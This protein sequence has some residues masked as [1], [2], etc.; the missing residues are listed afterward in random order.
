M[1]EERATAT[2]DPGLPGLA[3]ALD[4]VAVAP[5]LGVLMEGL[6]GTQAVAVRSIQV[7]RHK[8]GRRALI[9]YGVEQ[10]ER[11]VPGSAAGGGAGP[12]RVLG[13]LRGKG[14]DRKTMAAMQALRVHGFGSRS[15]D[16]VSV[17]EVIGGW[18]E[19]Q[20]WFQRRVAGLSLEVCL[21][22]EAGPSSL[23]SSSSLSP[24]LASGSGSE[25]EAVRGWTLDSLQ[26]LAGRV[27]SAVVKLQRC[28]V[29]PVRRHGVA[30]ELA[31]LRDRFERVARD[32][33]DWRAR[34]DALLARCE[35]WGRRVGGGGGESGERVEVPC[36]RDFHPA[37]L[38][39][40]E[41]EMF[42]GGRLWW[43]DFD[44]FCWGHPAL[45]VGN[46][47][48]HLTELAIRLPGRA[49]VLEAFR[50]RLVSEFVR[51]AAGGDEPGSAWGSS[52]SV[53][54]RRR[55]VAVWQGLS[56]ARH[57]FLSTQY[58]DRRWATEALLERCERELVGEPA[59]EPTGG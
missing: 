45:D 38:L 52:G 37:Q 57:V 27:A 13:K 3:L 18:P 50:D 29:Q 54:E 46:F 55:A 20:V 48:A 36:H 11:G 44:Q 59:V 12:V 35:A 40:E 41:G 30:D 51:R 34:L 53:T 26:E 32:R 43:L 15:A 14:L 22:V 19:A 56:L 28:G 17:P 16:G 10:P 24:A 4:P 1:R 9:E 49:A 5:V 6:G 7:V 23:P 33:P 21:G 2:I 58:A 39:V 42:G 47:A 25:T 8:P 31:I